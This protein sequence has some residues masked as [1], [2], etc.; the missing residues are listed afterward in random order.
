[1]TYSPK[2][3]EKQTLQQGE[4]SLC[5]SSV[6][7]GNFRTVYPL[8]PVY[9]LSDPVDAQRIVPCPAHNWPRISYNNPRSTFS[10]GSRLT[11]DGMKSKYPFAIPEPTCPSPKTEAAYYSDKYCN[12]D[13]P[14]QLNVSQLLIYNRSKQR[15]AKNQNVNR[16]YPEPPLHCDHRSWYCRTQRSYCSEQTGSSCHCTCLI[17]MYSPSY[18]YA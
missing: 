3:L 17:C 15:R 5:M 9:R 2:H 12:V 10:R 13:T 4:E 14:I 16:R 6:Q 11:P 7:F 18:G 8:T 1:M